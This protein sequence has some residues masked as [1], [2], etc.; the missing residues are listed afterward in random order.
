MPNKKL[1]SFDLWANMA[2]FKKPDVN[3]DMYLT[4]NVL[5]KPMLLGILGAI[6]GLDG[7]KK[8]GEIP[9]YYK[10]LKKLKIGIQPLQPSNPKFKA[11][12]QKTAI[13]YNNS[14]GYASQEEGGNLIVTEQTLIEPCFR[15]YVLIDFNF[16]SPQNNNLFSHLY[17]NLKNGE[18]HYI[19]YLGKNEFQASWMDD[20]GKILFK[21]YDCVE[22]VQPDR[23]F[24][25]SSLFSDDEAISPIMD[26]VDDDD[27]V[28]P[29]FYFENL[30]YTF[31]EQLLQYDFKLFKYT[32]ALLRAG[33]GNSKI[34]HLYK[35]SENKYVCLF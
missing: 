10:L 7:Y 1:V 31:H 29:F 6:V 28:T 14:V 20:S 17:H 22:E 18:A 12:Y 13:T 16:D 15:C 35:I 21:E 2:V 5:H 27:F 25:I 32:N 34:N 8:N 24:V 4:Y 11:S 9:E 19:P 33:K 23:D 30:P 3:K 26:S